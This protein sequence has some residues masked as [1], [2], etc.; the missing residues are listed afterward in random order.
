M[1]TK[2]SKQVDKLFLYSAQR[3]A[4]TDK[5]PNINHPFW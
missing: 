4:Y 2:F 1:S 5:V 3:G